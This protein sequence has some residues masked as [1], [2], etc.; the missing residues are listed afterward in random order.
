MAKKFR[1]QSSNII[2]F[3]KKFVHLHACFLISPHIINNYK[4]VRGREIILF[5]RKIRKQQY[6]QLYFRWALQ[7]CSRKK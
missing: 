6:Q 4:Y 7:E 5:R 3:I 1:K 2:L